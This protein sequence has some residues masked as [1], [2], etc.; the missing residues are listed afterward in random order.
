[1]IREGLRAGIWP[2]QDKNLMLSHGWA[3]SRR[4]RGIFKAHLDHD[5]GETANMDLSLEVFDVI[6]KNLGPLST[7]MGDLDLPLQIVADGS[8]AAVLTEIVGYATTS[9]ASEDFD[10]DA[11]EYSE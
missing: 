11:M 8:H 6:K 10:S 9:D 1:M 7:F 4:L 2:D 3:A 5:L